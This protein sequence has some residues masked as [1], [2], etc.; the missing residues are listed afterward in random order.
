MDPKNLS[1]YH[2]KGGRSKDTIGG[3]RSLESTKCETKDRIRFLNHDCS[4]SNV[5][6]E[7]DVSPQIVG[8]TRS[9]ANCYVD[10]GQKICSVAVLSYVEESIVPHEVVG[11]GGNFDIPVTDARICATPIK[12]SKA[13]NN[14]MHLI[15]LHTYAHAF[16]HALIMLWEGYY[17]V[18]LF[19]ISSFAFSPVDEV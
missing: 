5:V 10:V 9:K 3:L 16:P 11:N 1:N 12:I 7:Y 4:L 15:A 19:W 14:N 17:L 18:M 2:V 8:A 13:I 6:A